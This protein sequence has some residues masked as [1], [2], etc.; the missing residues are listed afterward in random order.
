MSDPIT[1]GIVIG[2]AVGAASGVIMSSMIK[3]PAQD[4]SYSAGASKRGTDFEKPVAYGRTQ[5]DGHFV[6]EEVLNEPI[7]IQTAS[8]INGLLGQAGAVDVNNY[9]RGMNPEGYKT[10]ILTF[11]EGPINAFKQIYIDDTPLFENEMNITNGI[12]GYNQISSF[13]RQQVQVEVSNGSRTDPH[14]LALAGLNSDNRWGPEHR[15]FGMPAIAIKVKLDPKNGRIKGNY[16]NVRAD[17]EGRMIRDIRRTD[18]AIVYRTTDGR[19]PGRNPVLI[20]YDYLTEYYGGQMDDFQINLD[21]FRRAA[22]YCEDNHL[23]CDGVVNQKQDVLKNIREILSSCDGRLTYINGLFG[24]HIDQPQIIAGEFSTDQNILGKVKFNTAKVEDYFN[25]LEVQYRDPFSNKQ[26]IVLYPPTIPDEVIARDGRRIQQRVEFKFSSSKGNIDFLASRAFARTQYRS[27]I[28]FETDMNGFLVTVGDVISV[29]VPEL[30][31]KNKT[32]RI[33]KQDPKYQSSTVAIVAEEY[34]EKVYSSFWTG[35]QSQGTPVIPRT[36]GQPQNLRT[37]V[38]PY[39]SGF[40]VKLLWDNDDSNVYRHCITYKSPK[41]ND[42]YFAHEQFVEANNEFILFDLMGG[43]YDFRIVAYDI[44]GTPSKPAFLRGVDLK[45]DTILPAVKGLKLLNGDISTYETS[46]TYFR[47]GWDS[48]LD[49]PVQAVDQSMNPYFVKANPTVKD[50]FAQYEIDV[51]HGKNFKG[52]YTSLENEFVYSRDMITKNGSPRDVQFKVRIASRGSATSPDTTLSVQNPQVKGIQ[53][54]EG[55]GGISGIKA[56]WL[57]C[58]ERD[59]SGT[60]VH[61]S[62]DPNFVPSAKTLVQ[63]GDNTFFSMPVDTTKKQTFYMYVGHYDVFGRENIK[64]SKRFVVQS[65][66]IYDEMT[67]LTKDNLSKELNAFI[68]NTDNEVKKAHDLINS[69]KQEIDTTIFSTKTELNKALQ[70]TK[71]KLEADIKKSNTDLTASIKTLEKVSNDGDSKLAARLDVLQA[72]GADTQAE[73]T[74]FKGT[75][76]EKDKA[77]SE[78]ISTL[79]ANM[80]KADNAIGAELKRVEQASTEGDKAL[81]TRIDALTASTTNSNNKQTAELKRVEQASTEADTALS[82]RVDALTATSNKADEQLKAELTRVEQASTEGD[83]ALSQRID[84]LTASTTNSDNKQTAELKRV[85]QASTAADQALSKR[86]DA[87]TA[88]TTKDK[89]DL[90]ASITKVEQA[91]TAADQA[92]TQKITALQTNVNG[93]SAK[94]ETTAKTVGDIQGNMTAMY[95]LKVAA[96]GSIASMGL[97]ADAKTQKSEIVFNAS[98]TLFTTPGSDKKYPILEVTDK[99]V[100]I[101]KALIGKVDATQIEAGAIQAHHIQANI[102][103]ANHIQAGTINGNHIT[104]SVQLNT[105]TIIMPNVRIGDGHAGFG[106]AAQGVPYSA[107]GV[108]WNTLITPDG[109]IYTN[110]LNAIGGAISNLTIGNCQINEDCRI[111][112][113]LYADKIIGMPSG[114]AFGLGEFGVPLHGQWSRIAEIPIQSPQGRFTTN[115]LISFRGVAGGYAYSMYGSVGQNKLGIRVLLGPNVIYQ[116]VIEATPP[117]DHEFHTS[118][119]S[120]ASPPIPTGLYGGTIAIE[121][122]TCAKYKYS[123][124]GWNYNW[125]PTPQYNNRGHN[126]LISSLSGFT[127][128]A[129]NR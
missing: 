75:V 125:A 93:I 18:N 123:N 24:I 32:F 64:F 92:Q 121:I 87:L 82:K 79:T 62:E 100:L 129:I 28:E 106:Q 99:G 77:V 35:V 84:A 117:C 127:Y 31:L 61:V 26:E 25:Q 74:S 33:I 119:F 86:V 42:S 63:E 116:E 124:G 13:F 68:D 48:A 38:V 78:Q 58:T 37:Q 120:W 112:G 111:N 40:T 5:V 44:T 29:T 22:Q 36:V 21:S 41:D 49:E 71:T 12:V 15:L 109:T 17:V 88:S 94:V 108:N 8:Y 126:V 103:N 16:F 114:K 122:T 80:T 96:D 54:V 104:A 60:E 19:E 23:Y 4:S 2:A 83:K 89:N 14:W 70:D 43:H 66:S 7:N 47:I 73:L 50:V 45:D 105:P 34:N 52:T 56:S 101:P 118:E 57:Q 51:F 65:H 10:F 128:N 27:E 102:I 90:S 6:F 59:Y 91:S 1:A 55:T 30:N 11:G 69:N 39:G 95:G 85:E 53:G 20:A 46:D 115:A 98:N 81:S 76:A 9:W 3:L 110:R 113:W 72:K 97:I 107:W 67:E